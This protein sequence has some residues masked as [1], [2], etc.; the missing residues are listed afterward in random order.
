MPVEPLRIH[1]GR[2]RGEWNRIHLALDG[3]IWLRRATRSR[4]TPSR[5]CTGLEVRSTMMRAPKSGSPV[6]KSR[7]L[8]ASSGELTSPA[9]WKL[10]GVR[11]MANSPVRSCGSPYDL[12]QDCTSLPGI[13]SNTRLYGISQTSFP[14]CL[15]VLTVASR[16]SSR[17]V[18]PL[19]ATF[20]CTCQPVA[21]T[22]GHVDHGVR[23]PSAGTANPRRPIRAAAG[24]RPQ[25]PPRP[26]SGHPRRCG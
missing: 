18:S 2:R 9:S 13:G 19:S 5:G 26:G 14:V 21:V 25:R 10:N 12:A 6:K 24:R 1:P 4:R 16:R 17:D 22:D 7:G 23:P 3:P 11:S 15:N 8:T 20:C